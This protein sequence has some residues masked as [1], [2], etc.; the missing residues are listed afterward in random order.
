MKQCLKGA[1]SWGR[2]LAGF[3][4]KTALRDRD[5]REDLVPLTVKRGVLRNGFRLKAKVRVLERD[6]G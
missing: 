5:F 2:V 1:D 4:D 6:G 3:W